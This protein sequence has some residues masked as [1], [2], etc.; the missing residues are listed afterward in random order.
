[1]KQK[2]LFL[3]V[4][5]L[6][7]VVGV[8]LPIAHAA[9]ESKLTITYKNNQLT[10][11]ALN[12][13]PEQLFIELGK[14]CK[15]DVMAHG[16]VFP[17]QEVTLH[18]ENLPIK[19]A[20]KKLVKT[21]GIRNYYMD[22]QGDTPEKTLLTKL[23]LFVRGSGE[24]VLTRSTENTAPALPKKAE[25]P[26]AID[27]REA[28]RSFVKDS[29]YRWDGSAMIDFPKYR[30]EL[31]YDKSSYSWQGDAKDFAKQSMDIIPPAVREGMAEALIKTCDEVAREKGSDSIT[32]DIAAA[33]LERLAQTANMPA[34]V[35]KNLPKSMADM[36]KPRV[37]IDPSNLKPEYR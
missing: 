26:Q 36:N 7:A 21:C 12:V 30:G 29:G 24:R 25:K 35:M 19:D 11:D 28:K 17:G 4:I 34:E 37:P 14:Q 6:V 2:I 1:M 23:E 9:A 16:D 33:A 3:K 10:L 32:V 20:I 13:K 22:F 15:I 8:M 31:A 5:F 18:F 27:Q